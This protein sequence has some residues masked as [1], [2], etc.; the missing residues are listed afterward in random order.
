MKTKI[1]TAY[2]MDVNGYPFQG[3]G[4]IRK[5][6]YLGSLISHCKNLQLPVI[7]YTHSKSLSEVEK[8]KNDF[9]L[10]NLEIKILELTNVK[11]HNEIN[12]IREINFNENLDGR[13]PEIMWGKFDILEREMDDCDRLYW[14]DCGLQH[15]G[16]FP[17]RYS[18]KYNKIEDHNNLTARW[19]E[20]YDVYNFKPIFNENIFNNLN[21][22]CDNK[23]TFL[24][25]LQPQ[26][27]YPFLGNG[28][29]DYNVLSPYPV[30]GLIGGDTK[31]LKKYLQYYWDFAKQVLGKKFLC[32]EEGIMKLSYDKMSDDEIFK[33]EFSAYWSGT[34]DEF[35]FEMWTEE[36]NNLKPLYMVWNDIL[37]L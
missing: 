34:H 26:I 37:N 18:G 27:S 30:G 35:H 8:I 24:L 5:E 19:W 3:S 36:S 2:W 32:T 4:S 29:I 23:I 7:C 13:G 16:I 1:V 14:V 33:L 9:N 6:R 20:E 17:W 21:I 11:F 12:Q 31:I 28:I 15:P 10:D 25:S 22:K